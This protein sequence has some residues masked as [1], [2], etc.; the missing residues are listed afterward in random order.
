MAKN[1]S[2]GDRVQG[3][4]LVMLPRLFDWSFAFLLITVP[5]VPYRYLPDFGP[6]L[7]M[8]GV[9]YAPVGVCLLIGALWGWRRRRRLTET[10]GELPL[11]WPLV[12]LLLT[13]L[14]S[15][16]GAE[17]PL[18]SVAPMAMAPLSARLAPVP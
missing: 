18:M 4:R 14:V 7:V 16:L 13:G 2:G 9:R 17:R 8:L 3:D 11:G 5:L 6:P 12:A 10:L 15:S 1:R